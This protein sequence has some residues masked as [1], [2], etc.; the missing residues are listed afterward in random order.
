MG[1]DYPRGRKTNPRESRLHNQSHMND[2]VRSRLAQRCTTRC[3][4]IAGDSE[5]AQLVLCKQM[6]DSVAY[7]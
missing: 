1:A 2:S 6:C 3:H 5:E 7:F 4:H